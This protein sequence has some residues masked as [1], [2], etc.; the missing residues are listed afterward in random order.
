M[1]TRKPRKAPAA[2]EK[3]PRHC[4]HLHM[5]VCPLDDRYVQCTAPLCDDPDRARRL[6]SDEDEAAWEREE[7]KKRAAKNARK[8]E[9]KRQTILAIEAGG[10][11]EGLIPPV[12]LDS[13]GKVIPDAH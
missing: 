11:F 10:L 13:K 8:R 5:D 1:A 7:M 3:K 4:K 6:R 12:K 9:A 2:G